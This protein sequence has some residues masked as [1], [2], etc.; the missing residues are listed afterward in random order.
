MMV[1][2]G[3]S[4]IS[5]PPL[6]K[7]RSTMRHQIKVD[8]GSGSVTSHSSSHSGRRISRLASVMNSAARTARLARNVA[9]RSTPGVHTLPGAGAIR[10][11]GRAACAVWRPAAAPGGRGAGAS[12]RAASRISAWR[13][14]RSMLSML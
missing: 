9:P 4:M 12:L 13:T 14:V 3:T 11:A 7:A 2:I 10:G 6:V 5:T 1:K 8:S